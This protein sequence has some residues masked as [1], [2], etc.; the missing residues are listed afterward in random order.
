M[1]IKKQM[2]EQENISMSA[3]APCMLPNTG[4]LFNFTC[5]CLSVPGGGVLGIAHVGFVRMLELAGIRFLGVGGA[6]AGAI[7]AVLVAAT[8]SRPDKESWQATQEVRD[9]TQ[10]NAIVL[11]SG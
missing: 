8:R 6:S 2:L 5:W 11:M 4:S 10:V 1:T 7:N 3:F 9:S